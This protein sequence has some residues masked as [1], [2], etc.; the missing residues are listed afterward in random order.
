M[1]GL[2]ISYFIAKDNRLLLEASVN[3]LQTAALGS[4]SSAA[5]NLTTTTTNAPHRNRVHL[6][7]L[8]DHEEMILGAFLINAYCKKD[9]FWRMT[10]PAGNGKVG[11]MALTLFYN[12][13][14]QRTV[15]VDLSAIHF[16]EPVRSTSFCFLSVVAAELMQR[17]LSED[18]RVRLVTDTISF[19]K[20]AV[21]E[22]PECALDISKKMVDLRNEAE[23]FAFA[24][25]SVACTPVKIAQEYLP[26]R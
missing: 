2:C 3:A 23:Q 4:S 10:A 17:Q 7:E 15:P 6:V 25:L 9:V 16:A 22:D 19:I 11:P 20:N 13:S 21:N 5:P 12:S 8:H 14:R 26:P 18:T 1:V 24:K